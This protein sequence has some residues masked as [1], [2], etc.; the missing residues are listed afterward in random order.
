[1]CKD[2]QAEATADFRVQASAMSTVVLVFSGVEL[3][4]QNDQLS[5]S[6]VIKSSALPSSFTRKL[7]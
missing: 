5:I 3:A 7:F 2:S 4:V 1:M 6:R